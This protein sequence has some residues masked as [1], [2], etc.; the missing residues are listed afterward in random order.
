MYDTMT[1]IETIK[2]KYAIGKIY[3]DSDAENPRE[4]ENLGTIACWHRKYILGDIQP[5][6]SPEEYLKT[7]KD[8]IILPL[9]LYDHSG[10]IMN[11]TGFSYPWDSGQVGYIHI[12]KEI[13]KKKFNWKTITK[14]RKERVYKILEQ[15]VYKYNQFLI[16]DTY[17]YIIE[18]DEDYGENYGENYG[19]DY[20]ERYN[21]VLEKTSGEIDSCWGF[22]GLEY[23][24]EELR[25]KIAQFDILIDENIVKKEIDNFLKKVGV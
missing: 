14:K 5:K 7:I 2:G 15:E 8:D 6:E 17:G 25:R 11:T 13:L 24:R 12:S 21:E 20:G 9:Y 19:E 3:Y 18:Y 23:V 10:I 22:Y 4:W 1:E 16:G